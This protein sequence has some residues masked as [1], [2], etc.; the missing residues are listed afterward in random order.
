MQFE[1]YEKSPVL[2]HIE[3]TVT[4]DQI[5]EEE[6]RN[7]S[8]LRKSAKVPGFRP[9][10]IPTNV[11]RQMYGKS[12]RSDAQQ[13]LIQTFLKDLIKQ[14]PDAL[15]LSPWEITQ[16]KLEDGGFSFTLDLE[17]RPEVKVDNYMGIDLEVPRSVVS[18]EDV[19][20]RLEALRL[21]HAV[22]EPVE[23]RQ[24]VEAG[25]F[26]TA[27][28]DSDVPQLKGQ[29]ISL[30]VGS[31]KPLAPLDEALPG[32]TVG[33]PF[34]LD[35][36]LPSD[37]PI[38]AMAN[39][40]ANAVVTIRAIRQRALPALDDSLPQEV[41]S[42]AAD[43]AALREELRQQLSDQRAEQAKQQNRFALSKRLRQLFPIDIPL[44]YVDSRAIQ[45]IQDQLN[46]M[47]RQGMDFSSVE[48]LVGR[49]L[50]GMRPMI[51]DQVHM[52]FILE[53]IADKEDV[54]AGESD[55]EDY[56]ERE[57]VRHKVT[58]ELIRQAYLSTP[59][60]RA[61]LLVVLRRDKTLDLILSAANLI[62]VDPTPA[63]LDALDALPAD[64]PDAA[65]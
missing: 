33:V 58:P 39:S 10:K 61:D 16:P 21:E 13:S 20:A 51:T 57:A 45:R 35:L 46:D 11:L 50:N 18:D 5:G 40:P 30:E 25:D 32:K 27:D 9:G 65:E 7:Y 28:I 41:G 22:F 43:L 64:A 6:S 19:D 2:R 62:E 36:T 56:F 1:V 23:D 8:K 31:G 15:H 60:V 47:R 29:D 24:V 14:F 59:G 12:V 4:G 53:A 55:L 42:D 17:I 26:I 49:M 52:E 48:P 44:Q 54:R 38:R 34:D 37:F 63:P 3:V